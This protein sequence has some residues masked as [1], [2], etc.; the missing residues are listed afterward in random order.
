MSQHVLKPGESKV[1]S[2]RPVG[3]TTYL[4]LQGG[5][6]D[7]ECIWHVELCCQ[8]EHVETILPHD[9]RRLDISKA[10]GA[11]VTVRND[12]WADFTAWTDY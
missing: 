9:Q 5:K 3:L 6:H 4:F 2:T 11:L 8:D 12:G 10:A 1:F 7:S